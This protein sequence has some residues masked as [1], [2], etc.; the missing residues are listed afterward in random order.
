V[1]EDLAQRTGRGMLVIAW[2]GA[3]A[4]G[5]YLFSGAV[6]RRENPN[7]EVRTSTTSGVSEVRL[8]SNRGGHY[9]ATGSINGREVKLM[10]DTGATTVAVSAELAEQL[11]LTRGMEIEL[12]TANGM[13]RGYLTTL[14][15]VRLGEIVLRDVQATIAPGMDGEEVL[16]GMSFLKDLELIQR[17]RE[18]TLRQIR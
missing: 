18:M 15:E 1:S 7:S 2:V 10:L 4:A 16:L 3:L 5:T 13:S 11:D 8:A 9:V 12:S 14:R 17:G 6:E